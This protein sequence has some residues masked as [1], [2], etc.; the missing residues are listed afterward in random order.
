MVLQLLNEAFAV[1]KLKE[2]AAWPQEGRIFAARTETERSLVCRSSAAPADCLAKEDGWRGIRV[3]G[4]LDFSLIG[5]LS[6]ITDVL[7]R[8]QV[9]VFVVSTYDTDYVFVRQGQLETARRALIGAGYQWEEEQ[10]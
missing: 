3:K 6:R 8:A 9:G 10:N 5:I 1:C 7:A 4:R 2:G